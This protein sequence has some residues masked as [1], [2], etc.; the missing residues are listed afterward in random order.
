MKCSGDAQE[1]ASSS[2]QTLNIAKSLSSEFTKP[3]AL[4][5]PLSAGQRY[6]LCPRPNLRGRCTVTASKFDIDWI[7]K[8]RVKKIKVKGIITAKQGLLPSVG[9]TDL[10]GVSLLVELISAETDPRTLM[11]KDPVKDHARRLVIDAHGEDQYECVFDMP[12]DFGAVGAIRVLNEAHRE[13]FLKEM[14]LELPDGPVTFTCDSWVASKSEDPTKR[15]FFSNKSYLPLQTPEP[16]KQLRK[17]E[18]ETLQGKNR[19]RDGEFKKFE[20][21]YDYDVYNDVGDPEKDPELARPVMG[22]L[23]HPYPRRCKTGR[24]PSRKYPSIETRKGDFYVPRD[25]EWS[26][27]K[28]T[29]FTGTTILAALPAVFPQIEAAL[30]DPNMPFPHFKSIEDLFEEG[31]ELPKNAGIFSLIPRLV[32]TVAEADDILQFDSPILLDTDRFSWIRDDEFARQTLAGLNPLCIELVQ[33]WPLKSKLDPAVYGDPNSLITS[34]IVER[35]IKGVMSFDEALENKR[36]FMLDYHDLLLPYVNKVRELDDS[37]LYASRTLFFLN[38]DSTLRPVAIELTRPQDVNSPQWRQ[39]FTPGYDATSCWLWSLAKTHAIT[40]DAAANRQLSAMHPI[41]RLLHP[42]FRYTME[43]NARGRQSLVNAGG[44]IESCFWP[45]KYSLEL[46]SDVYDKQW[47]GLAVEDETAEY[48]VRLTIPDYPFANDGLML[49][50]ALKEWIT[51]YVNHYYPDA[52]QVMLDEE[53]QGWWSEV[54]NIGHGDKKNEPWWP[55][56]K[57]QDDLIEVVTTIAWVASGHHAAVNFGQYGYGG[58]FPNRPTTS[59]IKM[60]VEEPTEEE[61]KEFYKDPEKTMLKTFPSKKQ[62]TKLMLTLD[63]LS[64]H[65]PDEEYLGENAEASWVHEPVIYAAYER[66][67]GKLQYLEGVIDERN[68]S[69]SL[70]TL[71]IA[72]SLSSEFTKPSALVNPLSAGHRYKLFP[73]PNLRGRCTVTTSKFDIDWIAK[74]NV[75]KIKVKGIITAKQGLLPS[76]GVTDLLG[77][78]LLVEL[79]SAET[80]P[81]TLMEKDPVKDNARRVLLDAHGEDQYECVFDMPEDFGPVGAIRVLNQDL[82]EIFLKEMKLELPDGSVTFTF[83][84]WVAPKSED[85]TKRTFFSNKSYLPLKTPEPLKQLRKQELET[86]QGKNR[87]RAGEFEKFERVYDYDVYNDLGSPDKDPELARPI[88]GGLSHPY[89]RRCKTGRKPCD[90]DP[91]A[92]TRKALE[93]YVPRDEEFTTVKGAQFTG[94]AVL[95]ALPAVFPQIEAAL[96][97]PNMPFPHFKS[98]EDLFEEGIELPK[99]AGLFPVIPRLVKAA[100]EAD[101]ILQ[102][103]SPSLLD[104]DRFSWIRDDEF[105]RQTLAGLNPYCIQLVQEWPLKSKLDPA[106]YGDPNSLITSEIVEREIKGVMSFDEALENK[107]LFML[108]YHDLLLPYVNKVRA[109]DD[110]TLYASRALFFL[111]DD[112]TLRPVAIELTRPQDVNRPQWRQAMMLPPA[113]YGFLLR[114]TLRTHCCIE[115]YIIAANRQLSA[116]HPIYRLLHPHFRYTMEINAR[117]RQVLINEGGIIESCFWPG[118]YS[119]ELSSD[120]YDK[121]WR[122]DREGLPA[123]LIGRNIGHGDKKNEPWWPVLK[124]QDDLIEVVTTIAWVASGHHAAV[125]FGQ[126]GYGGYFP[127][128]PTTS[129]IKMPVEEPTDEELKEFYEDPE[130][131][132][133]KTFPSKKQATIVM[134]TLDLLS[135]HSPDEEYL[136]ENPEA[137]WAHEPVIYAAYERF[138]GK[139]QYLEGVIDERNVNVSLKNR[140]GV[141]VVKYEL[142]KP[143]SEPGVTGMGVPYSALENK[144]LFMLD[145][146]DLLLPYVNKV[147]EL[148]DST[149]YASRTLFFLNDDSTLRPV[150]IELTRPQDKTRPQWRHVFTPGYD[151]TSCWLWTLAKTHVISHDA[152]YHQLI[153]HWGLAVED[154]TAEHGVRLTIPDYPFAND[155]LMLWDALKEWVRSD[156]ELKEWWNEVK[157]IG[158]GDKKNEPW[159]PDLK[160]QDDLIGVVTTIAWVAS[161]HHAAD[162]LKEF[163]EE[164]EKTMLKT[165][166]SKKQATT[167]MFT[168]DLLSAHSPDEE[169]LGENPEAS[170]VHEP[171]IYAAYERFKGKLQYLEGVIDERNLNVSLKNRAGAGVVKYELLK[172]ISGPGVTGMGVPYSLSSMFLAFVLNNESHRAQGYLVCAGSGEGYVVISSE[173]TYCVESIFQ[174]KNI[175]KY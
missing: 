28:G 151:A 106:V 134:V 118:K 109:L 154:E 1:K 50:D 174:K 128:R 59:R 126:Y 121:L 97:D 88:L 123:D 33:E 158:H 68:A 55:V 9:V 142:L 117:A 24:K 56:L 135:A 115:P 116:M 157:N 169:Y 161:G 171:V 85:P 52:E 7:P 168:L 112:S 159:W 63:L 110:S 172:P 145:Y 105:A 45:G 41:Y 95:A 155:G 76:V 37:T 61:L 120:V 75:K 60:P 167:V 53:L 22:G 108:D 25:E 39:L 4:I 101:D 6:K 81:R 46:S 31:I 144:R 136:G 42:H 141:G 77:V 90:K 139:L 27:V 57:T 138:K 30:V 43:I 165:F 96:V 107:R 125:N 104:K 74:D 54:R 91:S 143:I 34:E 160:T 111:S 35:E 72:K 146:H 21:V 89:P 124:T 83:N 164:P 170:W 69:S 18:L 153:S 49:W 17:E 86:L 152:G 12:E 40:H 47:R 73:R 38:D 70:Q 163:Y 82:K 67:K 84:S 16:L 102:F 80:D 51:D 44:I 14:K 66:F 62:A 71:N 79:I 10:L 26:T 2:L 19:K 147:R 122:F 175:R 150:A 3:S 129:R 8:E 58:Y 11:E 87:E 103:E 162:E 92:E 166:P 131:T 149:L 20:R 29:A 13:I 130:K 156:E 78:S 173:K 100:A 48:G 148:D 23:S 98:I 32:K 113:G 65:S 133:L 99:D 93:F 94:T 36:L 132:M 119:L 5:N 15:T 64:T 114:L 127:N 137:S 140:A